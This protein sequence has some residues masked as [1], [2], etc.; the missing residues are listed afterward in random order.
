[1]LTTVTGT[2]L[3]IQV[4]TAHPLYIQ[5]ETDTEHV[6]RTHMLPLM[7]TTIVREKNCSR[8]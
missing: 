3:L 5:P 8:H 7:M 4:D 2:V 6:I 1:M